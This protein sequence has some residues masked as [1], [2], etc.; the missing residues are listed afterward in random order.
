MGLET[1]R[2]RANGPQG[3]CHLAIA[4]WAVG[5]RR[6]ARGTL[7]DIKPSPGNTLDNIKQRTASYYARRS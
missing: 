1:V 3:R 2:V 7:D 6:E 4:G 5:P